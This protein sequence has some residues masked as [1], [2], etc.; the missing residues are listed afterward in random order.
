MAMMTRTVRV[1]A[2]PGTLSGSLVSSFIVRVTSQPQKM[3]MDSETP[4][5]KPVSDPTPKGLNHSQLIG[6]ASKAV[7]LATWEN[8]A[9]AN[10]PRTRT[11]KATSTYWKDFV[12]SIP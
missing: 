10:Q 2:R 9:I 1:A 8:A 5:A 6:V 12:V 3:K 4:A 11:W 7:L